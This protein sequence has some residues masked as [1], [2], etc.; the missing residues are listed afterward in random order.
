MKKYVVPVLCILLFVFVF[1]MTTMATDQGGNLCCNDLVGCSGSP[2]CND[3]GTQMPNCVIKCAD[4]TYLVC[5]S[6]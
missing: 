3:K 1:I 4:N 2:C 6:E 5:N